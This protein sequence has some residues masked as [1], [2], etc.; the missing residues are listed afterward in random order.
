M[1]IDPGTRIG[2]YEIA[3]A[4]GAGGMGEVYRATDKTL[5][6]DVA[7]KVLPK[8]FAEDED[9]IARFRREAELLASLNHPNIAQIYGLEETDGTT[10]IVM[11]LVDGPTLADRIQDGP[12]PP[13][14][15]LAIALQIT[16]ALEAAHALS[17]VH[18]DLKPANIKIKTDGT[19]RVLDFGIAKGVDPQ[20]VSSGSPVMTT[21]AVTQTGMILGTAAYMSPEQARGK[22]VDER[23]DIWAFG[24]LLYEMLTGQPAF[25]G[26]DVMLTLARVL[27]RETDMN[28]LPGTISRAV[29]HT[30]KLCL[31]KDPARRI[32]DIR[33]VRLALEGRFETEMP[34]DVP[35]AA[36]KTPAWRR[37]L[38]PVAALAVG[39]AIGAV[40]V[41]SLTVDQPKFLTQFAI[42]VEQRTGSNPIAISPDGQRIVYAAN[43]QLYVR[44]LDQTGNTAI[45]GT[46]GGQYPFFSPDGDTVAFFTNNELKTVGFAGEIPTVIA[47]IDQARGLVGTW[48]DN[49]QIYF[50]K[51]GSYPMFRVSAFGGTPEVFAEL[52]DYSDFD[53]PQLLPGGEWLMFS[54]SKT[55]G[56]FNDADIVVQNLAT[57]EREIVHEGGHYARYLDTGHLVFVHDGILNAALFDL[58]TRSIEPPIVPVVQEVA[59]ESGGGLAGYAIAANGTLVYASGSAT[60]G[61]SLIAHVDDDGNA[62]PLT[63]EL[64]NHGSIRLS[65]DS[66]RLAAEITDEGTG[67]IHIWIVDLDAD[68]GEQLTFDGTINRSPVWTP[69]GEEIVYWSDRDGGALW[70]QSADG[71]D[72]PRKLFDGTDQLVPTDFI[73]DSTLLYTEAS[74]ATQLDI[75]TVDIDS[76]DPPIPFLATEFSESEAKVGPTG[77][78]I[79]YQSNE[80]GVQRLFVRPWPPT[81]GG[82][83]AVSEDFG[84]IPI[85]SGGGD[86]IYFIDNGQMMTASVRYTPTTI[87]ISREQQ[88]YD[89]NTYFVRFATTAGSRP[90]D[91][92]EHDGVP[93]IVALQ[94][95]AG[96]A[97]EALLEARLN[98][99]LNWLEY[100]KERVP[101]E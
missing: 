74:D 92:M 55:N 50:G 62:T 30:I 45:P 5:K 95:S 59:A 17:I 75:L 52:G 22:F 61:A 81:G 21:P 89:F 47:A 66:T 19:I 67:N 18:R 80:A 37:A 77:E 20:A 10:A 16:G 44:R 91:Y 3:E 99:V 85:W 78:W 56:N 100:L 35:Q 36:K 84:V 28:S 26:E 1:S 51:S 42:D 76:D 58:D 4:I 86:A 72:E 11:E 98:I 87:T 46:E 8:Y 97:T 57:G 31:A 90:F 101:V 79:V 94:P 88:R 12:L 15:A 41:A 54:A 68:D 43:D 13:D 93:G 24:C 34:A 73:D 60:G 39:G 23:T 49:G 2:V 14:E 9:R 38:L 25:G 82:Q 40:V 63:T 27:D 64:H 65:P 32:A 7:I 71:S 69:D 33:D 53:Y 6:R 48:G 83:K 96:D 70:I 29:R